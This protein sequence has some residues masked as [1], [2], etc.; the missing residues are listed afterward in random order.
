MAKEKKNDDLSNLTRVVQG[1][2]VSFGGSGCSSSRGSFIWGRTPGFALVP[3]GAVP[4]LAHQEIFLL[5]TLPLS[6]DRLPMYRNDIRKVEIGM[7][8][9]LDLLFRVARI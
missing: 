2:E 3:P 9:S 8:T 5:R 7:I 1:A 6:F 4:R